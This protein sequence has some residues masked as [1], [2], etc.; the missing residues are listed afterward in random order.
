[1]IVVVLDAVSP[2]VIGGVA[3]GCI[4]L[5][6]IVTFILLSVIAIIRRKYRNK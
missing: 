1:M 6:A 5:V 4:V 2:V 3:L